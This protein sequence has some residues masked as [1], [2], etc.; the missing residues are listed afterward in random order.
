MKRRTFPFPKEALL[1]RQFF[2]GC[3]AS[4]L[5]LATMSQG[6][7]IPTAS[8][9][10]SIQFGVAG[11]FTNPDFGQSN[12]EQITFYGDY[13]L[14]HNL[15]VEGVIHY[16][17]NTPSDVSEN[18]YLVG[19]RYVLHYKR[20]DP[21]AKVLFGAGHFGLQSGSF[22]NP[23]TSTY[24]EYAVGAG[25]DVHVKRHINIRAIDFEAQ[26]W[27]SFGA[28]GLSPFSFSF[29]VSYVFH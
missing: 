16:S 10:G 24:F 17:V 20:F 1:K 15:G 2:I 9:I 11:T 7:A 14:V 5:S 27:P 18:S 6:Q 21:Y 28:H 19:P 13:D 8:R 3:L 29:G 22:A 26:K 12:I 23:N 25:V 4:V